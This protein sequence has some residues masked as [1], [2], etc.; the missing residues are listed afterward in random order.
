MGLRSQENNNPPAAFGN[1]RGFATER[2]S[3]AIRVAELP[4][5]NPLTG[6]Q[7]IAGHLLALRVT[8]VISNWAS[9]VELS[10]TGRHQPLLPRA[11]QEERR[12][13]V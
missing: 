4:A 8:D 6:G 12:S 10:A 13:H 1:G 3:E 9:M 7:T 5:A 11:W 2:R